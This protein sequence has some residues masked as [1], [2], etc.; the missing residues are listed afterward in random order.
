VHK[1]HHKGYLDRCK[2]EMVVVRLRIGYYFSMEVEISLG[3]V[4]MLTKVIRI[5]LLQSE[6]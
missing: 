2:S 5:P 4:T 6:G 1:D 3:G